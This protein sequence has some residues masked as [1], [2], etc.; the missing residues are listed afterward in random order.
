MQRLGTAICLAAALSVSAVVFVAS[1]VRV[2]KLQPASG[3][4]VVG[5]SGFSQSPAYPSRRIS[6]TGNDTPLTMG[7][8]E[9]RMAATRVAVNNNPA[10]IAVP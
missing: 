6:R 1:D 3:E 8:V 9:R 4:I 7:E 2:S 5:L 10:L